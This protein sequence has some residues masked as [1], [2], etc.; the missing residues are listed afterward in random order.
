MHPVL[1]NKQFS[2]PESKVTDAD[3][4]AIVSNSPD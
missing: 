1:V 3:V 2:T 4:I